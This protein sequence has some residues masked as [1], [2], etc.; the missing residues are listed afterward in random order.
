M[1]VQFNFWKSVHCLNHK[2]ELVVNQLIGE[3]KEGY[4]LKKASVAQLAT[5]S[6]SDRFKELIQ[7]SKACVSV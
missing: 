5:G 1:P 3:V 2:T 4:R 7:L 6:E